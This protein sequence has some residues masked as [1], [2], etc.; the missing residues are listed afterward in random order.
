MPPGGEPEGP[1]APRTPAKATTERSDAE[2]IEAKKGPAGQGPLAEAAA[3]RHRQQ[4]P[5]PEPAEA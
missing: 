2:T 3:A 1:R 5:A 4:G